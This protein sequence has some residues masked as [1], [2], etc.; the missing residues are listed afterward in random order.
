M[1]DQILDNLPADAT[2]YFTQANIPRALNCFE[3]K[4]KAEKKGLKGKAFFPVKK[5]LK[6][7]K[8]VSKKNDLIYVGGSTFVVS[9][10][11]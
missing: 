10:V 11:L 8:T 7:A 3:L 5:A 6:A 2:Y 4:Q 1:L 9:E